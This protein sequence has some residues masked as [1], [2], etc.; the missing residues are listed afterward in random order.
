MSD[1]L[2]HSGSSSKENSLISD[3]SLSSVIGDSL[4]IVTEYE[5]CE[6]ESSYNNKVNFSEINII[7]KLNEK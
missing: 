4:R 5:F 3:T 7:L 6:K 2:N 1:E